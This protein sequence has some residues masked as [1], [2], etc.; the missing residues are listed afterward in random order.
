MK[1]DKNLFTLRRLLN[2][3][4]WDKF[5]ANNRLCQERNA[6]QNERK[7]DKIPLNQTVTSW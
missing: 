4:N 7:C 3:Y 5:K 6:L 1:V 2:Q